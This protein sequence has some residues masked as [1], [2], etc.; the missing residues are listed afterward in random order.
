MTMQSIVKEQYYKWVVLGVTLIGGFMSV[1]DSSIVNIAI[2]KLMAV[3]SVDSED[4]QWILTSYTLAMGVVQTTTGYLAS[5]FGVRK[6]YLMSLTV[7]TFGSGLCSLAWS[8]YSMVAFRVFQAIG[9]GMILPVSM[10]A[11]LSEF[12]VKERNLAMA[13][14]GICIAVAPAIGPTL[15]GYLV[16]TWNWHSIFLINIPIGISDCVL[17]AALLKGGNTI[18]S[19]FDIA[20]FLFCSTG[21]L[22]LL[23][24]LNKA[25]D[26]G[27]N[28][29]YIVSLLYIA[30]T[31]FI[32]FILIELN[33]K[34]PMLDLTLFND[35]NFALGNIYTAFNYAILMGS[36]FLVPL[37]FENITGRTAMET[38][39]LLLP[40]SIVSAIC[41]PL[42]GKIADKIGA[43]P[44]II[45]ASSLALAATFP[46]HYLDLNTTPDYVL[47]IQMFRGGFQGLSMI[48]VVVLSLSNVPAAKISQASALT[49][50]IRQISGSFGI[51]VLSTILQNRKIYHLEHVAEDINSTSQATA[52]LLHYGEILFIQNGSTASL[53]YKQSLA[54]INEM[55]QKQVYIFSIDDAFWVLGLFAII[56]LGVA[57]LLKSGI[58]AK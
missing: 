31:A 39:L 48:T 2:P 4:V 51:A 10:S 1:L 40:A 29:V 15:G 53:A 24:A 25:I 44:V 37:F 6:V 19:K 50:T 16:D 13:I 56:C 49:T 32:L 43:K 34:E 55:I 20:G 22:C 27:W 42:A 11:V 45:F 14:W 7:F 58:T 28:S 5:R 21:L 33:Q 46:L 18:K 8:N 47:G 54:T 52:Q 12:P 9:A 3:F 17:A 26:K 41:M 36:I 30:V 38:G 57:C 35:W 23:L